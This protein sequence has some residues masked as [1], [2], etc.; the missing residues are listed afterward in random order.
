ML[1]LTLLSG[2][3]LGS[4]QVFAS[5]PT[6]EFTLGETI[7]T[8]T[9]TTKQLL[10]TP[11]NAQVIT[12]QEIK[13]GGFDN[14]FEVV[15]NLAQVN[16]HTYQDDGGD[17]GG[18]MSR[19][20]MRGIDNGTLVLINGN[21][22]TFMNN[23]NL[24]S[25]PIDQ[26]ERIEIVKGAGSVLYGPQAMGGVIN[27]ITKK[28]EKTGKVKGSVYGG[29]GNAKSE[30]GISIQ[31]DIMNIGFKESWHKDRNDIVVPGSTGNGTTAINLKDKGNQQLFL[32]I[33]LAKDLNF[34]YGR[35]TNSVKYESGKY[36]NFVPIMSKL[37]IFDTTYNNYSLF[38]N[39]EDNGWR[40]VGGYS[41]MDKD[42][43]YDKS[44]PSS[45]NDGGY[46]GY[47][48]NFDMQKKLK[49]RGGKDSLILGAN[50]T[51][52]NMENV[53]GSKFNKN[54]RN[55]YSLYQSYDFSPTDKL[56]FIVGLREYYLT[57]SSYQ[58]SNFQLLP[59]IQGLYKL[60]KNSTYYF[61]VGKSFEMP[62]ISSAF[63][64]GDNYELN[65]DLKPQSSW[66]YEVGYKYEDDKRALNADIFYVTVTDKFYWDKTAD[67]ANILRNR[68]EWKN[69]GLELN[70]KQ[71][72]NQYWTTSLG[73]TIQNPVA[74]SNGQWVQD[75]SKYIVNIGANYRH[76]KLNVDTR[77]FAYLSREDAFYNNAHTSSSIKDHK[78]KDTLD[79]TIA[80]NYKP[81]KFDSFKL[82]GR[83]LLNR[84]D[85]LNN[86]EYK[87]M[88]IN[89][90]LSYERS[91]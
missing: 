47:N 17:Y 15:R 60:N 24:D 52:E 79:L 9:R 51:K 70:Y 14:V 21:P 91:F 2:F 40:I 62:S 32:D 67:G 74:K 4:T 23:A 86:Y 27:I 90:L 6:P 76:S 64:Y 54:S 46:S 30:A 1:L 78:L 61:N 13:E 69:I 72:L 71:K 35:T 31:T 11:A 26:I 10:D 42:N 48:M 89:Y 83:N 63:S 3:A 38:Y 88:P 56:E 59:Q 5:E 80:L 12:S 81:T 29:F 41:T 57:K 55:S 68:D 58:N 50:F 37:G 66:S 36:K 34:S 22:G 19:I 33:Q 7:V 20:R 43:R 65:T 28:P 45:S 75:T 82:V 84:E 25:I 18:M 73:L 39:N 16:A 8:A 53:S 85:T 44:Y 77:L 49:L 87:T